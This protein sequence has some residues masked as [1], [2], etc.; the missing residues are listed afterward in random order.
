MIEKHVALLKKKKERRKKY[1]LLK[2]RIEIKKNSMLGR[3]K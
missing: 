3:K 2:K 1:N